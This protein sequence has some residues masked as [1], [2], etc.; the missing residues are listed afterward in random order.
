MTIVGSLVIVCELDDVPNAVRQQSITEVD[1]ANT[2]S[3]VQT[4][5]H[6][7]STFTTV[8]LMLAGSV[9]TILGE[10]GVLLKRLAVEMSRSVRAPT[11]CRQLPNQKRHAQLCRILPSIN[12]PSE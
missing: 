4:E 10:E 6:I 2:F 9:R 5:T 12:K 3:S 8:S 7:P 1:V 11:Q